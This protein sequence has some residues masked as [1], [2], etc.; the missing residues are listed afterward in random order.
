MQRYNQ[1]REDRRKVG[2]FLP[3]LS[4]INFTIM[5]I[6]LYG[7]DTYRSRQKLNEIIEQYKKVHKSG[8]NLRYLDCGKL[9]FQDFND[10]T[11]QTSMF[12]EKKM[13]IL[14]NSFSN[15]SL[16]FPA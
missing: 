6:F 8:L 1:K 3:R 4:K 10:E 16:S 2:T 7:Q 13:V 14:T 15:T 5:I 12:K 9:S 11:R